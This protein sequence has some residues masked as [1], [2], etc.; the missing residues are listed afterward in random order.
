MVWLES[1][2]P[3]KPSRIEAEPSCCNGFGLR[4]L[5]SGLKWLQVAFSSWSRGFIPDLA[6]VCLWP[7]G[8][9]DRLKYIDFC[10]VLAHVTGR[11]NM[12]ENTSA[13]P[14]TFVQYVK[15]FCGWIVGLI[16]R[17]CF[18][19][20]LLSC[21]IMEIVAVWY[22]IAISCWLAHLSIFGCKPQLQPWPNW[23]KP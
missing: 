2:K 19:C 18:R 14:F 13:K 12:W 1:H 17:S 10:M 9:D 8:G 15:W 4:W 6:K 7:V 23:V 20:V 22:F 11:T 5:G 21:I 3:N 16:F